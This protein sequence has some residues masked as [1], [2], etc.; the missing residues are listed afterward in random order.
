M[1]P[2]S[3]PAREQVPEG[4]GFVWAS[5]SD[6]GN[7]R[8]VDGWRGNVSRTFTYYRRAVGLSEDVTFHSLRHGFCTR[9]AEAGATAVEIKALARHSDIATSMRYIHLTQQHL[10]R[11]LDDLT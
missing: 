6:R 7:A 10:K 3:K 9:L 2:L 8:S 5:P 11:R 1:L 4:K